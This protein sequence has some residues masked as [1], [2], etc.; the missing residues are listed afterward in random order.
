MNTSMLFVLNDVSHD[1]YLLR[2]HVSDAAAGRLNSPEWWCGADQG[3]QHNS[4]CRMISI[5]DAGT[6]FSVQTDPR[7]AGFVEVRSSGFGAS[8]IT[9]RHAE[10]L[11]G[12]WDREQTIYRPPESN[13]AEAFVYGA[14]SHPELSGAGMLVTYTANANDAKLATDMTIYFPRFVRIDFREP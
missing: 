12:P 9:M 5:R 3:W 8:N 1:A 11:E 13:A 2:W 10:R 4:P 14:K 6:E 7:G